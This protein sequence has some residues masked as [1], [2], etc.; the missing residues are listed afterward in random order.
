MNKIPIT[1]LS[2]CQRYDFKR[3]TIDT[4]ADRMR[5]LSD[6][7][8]IK[9]EDRALKYIAK[10][11]NGSMR[12]ALS[13]LDQCAAYYM[14]Q[15]LSYDNVLEV[16]GAVD[17]AVYER[18]YDR[19]LS[20]DTTGSIS[21]LEDVLMQGR[22]LS[23]FVTDFTWYLRNLLLSSSQDENMEE[24]IDVS[25]ETLE[26]MK[27]EAKKT[28]P[29]T[30]MRFIRIFS[31]LSSEIRYAAEKKVLTEIAIIKLMRPEMETDLLSIKQRVS[32]LEKK[33]AEGVTVTVPVETVKKEVV[34]RPPVPEA[35]PEDIKAAFSNWGRIMGKIPTTHSALISVLKRAELTVKGDTLIIAFENEFENRL[36]DEDNC[37]VLLDAAEQVIGKRLRF[38]V[39]E[40]SSTE[41]FEEKYP[42]FTGM[43][44]LDGIDVGEMEE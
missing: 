28:D 35:L 40:K 20:K 18:L 19:I 43:I 31:G 21:V 33:V 39:L 2:R 6:L 41:G 26:R 24:V 38:E 8:G 22:D 14:D 23:A 29:D 30:L 36:R 25:S 3:M 9:A 15:E 32:E 16:L 1:V 7:E 37:Q 44:N 34:K 5:E 10:C 4:M 42:D 27:E 12:D 11:A 13:L 17:T